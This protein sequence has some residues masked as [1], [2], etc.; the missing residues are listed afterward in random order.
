MITY[1]ITDLQGRVVR[2]SNAADVNEALTQAENY[3]NDLPQDHFCIVIDTNKS[4]IK[5][6]TYKIYAPYGEAIQI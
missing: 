1:I 6:S 5:V 2:D 3:C 4:S